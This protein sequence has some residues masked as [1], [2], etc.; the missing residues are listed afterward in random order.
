MSIENNLHEIYSEVSFL[1]VKVYSSSLNVGSK[2]NVEVVSNARSVSDSFIA[3]NGSIDSLLGVLIHVIS[4][5]KVLI[6][7]NSVA[8]VVE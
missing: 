5:L 3:E 2:F 7:G 4:L 1:G 8:I 6:V